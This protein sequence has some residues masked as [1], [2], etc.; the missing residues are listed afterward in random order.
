MDAHGA[1]RNKYHPIDSPLMPLPILVWQNALMAVDTAT[2]NLDPSNRNNPHDGKYIFPEPGVLAGVM[3]EVRQARYFSTWKA[4]KSIL[5]FRVFN[6]SST[7][8]PLSG[9]EWRD[10]L[11]GNLN[12]TFKGARNLEAQQKFRDLF[13]GCLDELDINF[14]NFMP[15]TNVAPSVIA[16]SEAQEVLWELSELNFRFELSSLDRRASKITNETAVLDR[17]DMICRCFPGN[18]LIVERSHA[19]RGLASLDWR[20]RLPILLRLRAL[21]QDWC[22]NKPTPLLLQDRETLE[23]YSEHD[24]LALEDGIARFYTQSF[25][26]FFGRAAVIPTRLPLT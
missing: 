24:V 13:S 10:F 3:N 16:P 2:A 15:P 14:D 26:N 20:E 11:I 19:T 21:M 5:L 6:A 12:G 1:G 8:I 18:T 9:Q 25:F 23:L 22:G 17:Q 7:A 4:T